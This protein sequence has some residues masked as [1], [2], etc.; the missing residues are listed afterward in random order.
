[1]P[2][3]L[4]TPHV[5][6]QT[7]ATQRMPDRLRQELTMIISNLISQ[8]P[9][10]SINAATNFAN[11][12]L[13]KISPLLFKERHNF[14][15]NI[16]IQTVSERICTIG[17]QKKEANILKLQQNIASSSLVFDHW[18][19]HSK[20]FFCAISYTINA[21]FKREQYCVALKQASTG[22]SASGYVSD[23][24]PLLPQI[25]TNKRSW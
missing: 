6:I 8:A 7:I 14:D 13:N 19:S 22:K 20:N 12:F 15:F 18:T 2:W 21:N 10:L 23:F 16:S 9:T 3:K 11:E 4:S 25:T 5:S 17:A 24:E 1:M